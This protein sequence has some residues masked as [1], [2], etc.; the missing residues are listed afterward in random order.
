MSGL[1]FTIVRLA[2]QLATNPMMERPVSGVATVVYD[3]SPT[4]S[5]FAAETASALRT[6]RVGASD[7]SYFMAACAYAAVAIAFCWTATVAVLR[8]RRMR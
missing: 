2:T 5:Q 8:G 4:T 7:W 6:L 3:V 1:V